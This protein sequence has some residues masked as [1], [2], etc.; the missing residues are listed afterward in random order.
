MQGT[1]AEKGSEHLCLESEHGPLWRQK[2][3]HRVHAAPA[4]DLHLM[5]AFKVKLTLMG[6]YTLSTHDTTKDFCS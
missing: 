1:A 5:I 4:W 3:K 2:M 6:S